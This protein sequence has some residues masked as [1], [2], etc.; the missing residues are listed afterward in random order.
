MALTATSTG[1][2]GVDTVEHPR[3]GVLEP[4]EWLPV[5][6]HGNVSSG[7]GRRRLRSRRVTDVRVT[8]PR[9]WPG[10]SLSTTTQRALPS[11]LPGWRPRP[12]GP[13]PRA[14]SGGSRCGRI[15][16][17]TRICVRRLAGRP[18]TSRRSMTPSS[19]SALLH[20]VDIRAIAQLV[21]GEQRVQGQ[22]GRHHRH[23]LLERI[24]DIQPRGQ[25]DELV[26][27]PC[28]ARGTA[29]EPAHQ[30][31]PQAGGRVDRGRHDRGRRSSPASRR[32]RP[33][34]PSDARRPPG[35]VSSSARWHAPAGRR[36]WVR[37]DTGSRWPAAGCRPPGRCTPRRPARPTPCPSWSATIPTPSATTP[38]TALTAGPAMATS[39]SVAGDRGRDITVRRA[40]PSGAGPRLAHDGAPSSGDQRVRQL[41]GDDRRQQQRG[42]RQRW[43]RTVATGGSDGTSG[44]VNQSTSEPAMSR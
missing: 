12:T 1:G 20:G 8:S 25:A 38:S 30:G 24:A 19:T 23:V 27:R 7:T 34:R 14:P 40:H 36:P 6:A 41:V 4:K 44:S 3:Q 43:P 9:R 31:Q 22:A 39:A 33:P 10:S 17:D 28:H 18:R 11:L 26:L 35:P 42:H 29:Q 5:R 16:S 2:R 13:G 37:R 15:R 21:L 32:R